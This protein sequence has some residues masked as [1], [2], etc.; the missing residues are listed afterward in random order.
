MLN[1][2]LIITIILLL[3]QITLGRGCLIFVSKVG[4]SIE[5]VPIIDNIFALGYYNNT[6]CVDH[7]RKYI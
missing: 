4:V 2:V 6:M 3:L 5:T 7:F 1:M